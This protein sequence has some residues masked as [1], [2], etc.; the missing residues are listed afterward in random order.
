MTPDASSQFSGAIKAWQVA[1]FVAE[2]VA[3]GGEARFRGIADV[4][5]S[6]DTALG[7]D[8][9]TSRLD[10]IELSE[11]TK[12]LP[13]LRNL[14]RAERKQAIEKKKPY[15]SNATKFSMV[16]PGANQPSK[17]S[18]IQNTTYWAST[19]SPAK[20][21][22]VRDLAADVANTDFK[23]NMAAA[24]PLMTR[25]GIPTKTWPSDEKSLANVTGTA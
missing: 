22:Q 8:S 19:V 14:R 11:C 20:T 6:S 13:E 24:S 12:L 25:N 5:H 15:F 9:S 7:E 17:P 10:S 16:V 2:A 1:H 21:V 4:H 3:F 18:T 23:D